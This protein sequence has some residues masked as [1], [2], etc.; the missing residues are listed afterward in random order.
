MKK[1][2]VQ[3]ASAQT[4]DEEFMKT[5]AF[6]QIRRICNPTEGKA[7]RNPFGVTFDG[8]HYWV[9]ANREVLVAIKADQPVEPSCSNEKMRESIREMLSIPMG[10]AREVNFTRLQ[11]WAEPAQWEFCDRCDGSKVYKCDCDGGKHDCSRC[12]EPHDC[13]LCGGSGKVRCDDHGHRL[14]T[15]PGRLGRLMINREV[16]SRA[17]GALSADTVRISYA[18]SVAKET[19]YPPI[20]ID[21]GDWR[22]VL[23]PIRASRRLAEV[24]PELILS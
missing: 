12:D 22:V 19:D 18:G 2:F 13:R 21:G 17:I 5:I 9:A 15:R 6:D 20:V 16:L 23:M 7:L 24:S 3:Q 4:T 11:Q 8:R 14:P 10:D 1:K